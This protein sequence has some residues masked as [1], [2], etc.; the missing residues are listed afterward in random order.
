MAIQCPC[1]GRQYDVTLFQFGRP[2]RCDCGASVDLRRGHVVEEEAEATAAQTALQP[3]GMAPEPA[4]R[5]LLLVR[6]AEAAAGAP[7]G[8]ALSGGL[9]GLGRRQAL[10]LAARLLC[11]RVVALYTSDAPACRETAAPIAS[12]LG[13]RPQSTPLLGEDDPD[14]ALDFLGLAVE[15]HP[16]GGIV[17][18]AGD[19]VCRAALCRALALPPE[20]PATFRI[21]PASLH[22]IEVTADGWRV[23]LVNDTCH[24]RGEGSGS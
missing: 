24:L 1:C 10:A 6:H 7:S 9:S 18:V 8:A 15:R 13:V 12:E 14:A 20:A 23:A 16:Q 21:D 2:V 4:G 5:H 22:R 11:E 19:A 17:A 3:R